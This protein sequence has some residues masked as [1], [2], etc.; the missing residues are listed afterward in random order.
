MRK[1]FRS[2][3]KTRRKYKSEERAKK[4]GMT[5]KKCWKKLWFGRKKV[6]VRVLEE[7][8]TYFDG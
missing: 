8:M 6:L 4:T 5:K 2:K 1:P 3:Y 7:G